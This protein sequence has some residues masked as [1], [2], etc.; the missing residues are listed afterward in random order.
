MKLLLDH[1]Y[2]T[3]IARGLRQRGFDVVAA[4]AV[5]LEIAPDE[6]VL[7]FA[8][9]D[10]RALL[11]NDVPGFMRIR[12]TWQADG[13]THYG[14]LFTSDSS[15]SRARN[16]IGPLIARLDEVLTKHPKDDHLQDQVLWL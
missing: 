8:V 14:L 7:E 16:G 9:N 12:R 10:G 1:H 11:T 13:R 4:N 15:W 2:S 5:G 6:Q 3:L